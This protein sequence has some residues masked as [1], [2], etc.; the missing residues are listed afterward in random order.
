M[1]NIEKYIKEEGGE[2]I[3]ARPDV[4]VPED[5][6]LEYMRNNILAKKVDHIYIASEKIHSFVTFSKKRWDITHG[7]WTSSSLKDAMS[8]IPTYTYPPKSSSVPIRSLDI[9]ERYRI[10]QDYLLLKVNEKDW[11]GVMDAAADL[12]EFEARNLEV[13]GGENK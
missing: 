4:V 7:W 3:F 12:R 2:W 11:H 8:G 1:E 13:L 10:Y 9:F 5:S 6:L